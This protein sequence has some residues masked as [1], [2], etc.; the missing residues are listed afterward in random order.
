ME[1]RRRST[2]CDTPTRKKKTTRDKKVTGAELHEF[3][4]LIA[5]KDLKPCP[6]TTD[7]R[8]NAL[9][10]RS[11]KHIHHPLRS[12]LRWGWLVEKLLEKKM[13]GL[14]KSLVP[15]VVCKVTKTAKMFMQLDCMD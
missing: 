6:I 11:F 9:S 10:I 1:S 15:G 3:S 13:Y 5:N 4:T 12:A 7:L 2:S 8:G 14:R